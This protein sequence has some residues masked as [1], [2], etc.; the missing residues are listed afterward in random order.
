MIVECEEVPFDSEQGARVPEEP[1]EGDPD[2]TVPLRIRNLHALKGLGGEVRFRVERM[3]HRV[4]IRLVLQDAG[5]MMR[6]SRRV[7]T[8]WPHP[9]LTVG[10]QAE[11]LPKLLRALDL[12]IQPLL[13]PAVRRPV[14]VSR[15]LN[16]RQ[17]VDGLK[18]HHCIESFNMVHASILPFFTL[19]TIPILLYNKGGY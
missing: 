14:P 9:E 18:I 17:P 4:V 2:N 5:A 11:I 15:P 8:A 6:R 7:G 19:H 3:Q 12:G 1:E 13:V 10:I 16:P